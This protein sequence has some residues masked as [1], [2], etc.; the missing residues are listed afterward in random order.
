LAITTGACAK[1]H[2]TS[3]STDRQR[4]TT[5]T[6]RQDRKASIIQADT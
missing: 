3:S 4:F 6:S 5:G 1:P 2:P